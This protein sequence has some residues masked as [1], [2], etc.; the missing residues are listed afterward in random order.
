MN[1]K[2]ILA[3][4]SASVLAVSA[5]SVVAFAGEWEPGK[6]EQSFEATEFKGDKFNDFFGAEPKADDVVTIKFEDTAED[7]QFTIGV[8]L[9]D[10]WKQGNDDPADWV[11]AT[12][13]TVDKEADDDGYWPGG[14]TITLPL[15]NVK[16]GAADSCIKVVANTC[17][18]S[19]K[20]SWSVAAGAPAGDESTPAE[21]TPADESKPADDKNNVPTGVEGV[22]AV[23]GVA[24]VAAG[25]MVVAKKRK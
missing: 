11:T 20:V 12:G 13:A 15:K 8:Q 1:M 16:L 9:N 3:A 25:A 22:A 18:A 7:S 5:M 2:K 23:L 10:N 24:A 21:S 4:A 17:G 19:A 6:Q 14:T